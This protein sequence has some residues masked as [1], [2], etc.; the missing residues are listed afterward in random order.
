MSGNELFF[1][2]LFSWQESAE[3]ISSDSK[4]KGI[5][6]SKVKILRVE[7]ICQNNLAKL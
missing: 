6:E 5:V 1:S 7:K 2:S 3:E 4:L